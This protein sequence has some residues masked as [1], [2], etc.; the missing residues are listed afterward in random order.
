M[1]TGSV[2]KQYLWEYA[3]ASLQNF[4][5]EVEFYDKDTRKTDGC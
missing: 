5:A 4:V 2:D 3:T 1:S